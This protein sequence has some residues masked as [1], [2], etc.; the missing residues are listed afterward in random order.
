MILTKN[1]I[2][3]PGNRSIVDTDIALVTILQVTRSGMDYYRGI[4]HPVNL[5]YVY[6]VSSGKIE[7]QNDFT[8]PDPSLPVQLSDLEQIS[9]KYKT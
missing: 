7:F 1:Y 9:V 2:G 4:I 8:G 3:Y 5:Q 6:H